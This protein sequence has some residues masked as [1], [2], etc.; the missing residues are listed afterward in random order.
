MIYLP[1]KNQTWSPR[2][3]PH[4][5]LRQLRHCGSVRHAAAMTVLDILE[6]EKMETCWFSKILDMEGFLIWK[7]YPGYPKLIIHLMFGCSMKKT[8]NFKKPRYGKIVE[9]LHISSNDIDVSKCSES[10]IFL[11]RVT[12]LNVTNWAFKSDSEKWKFGP[13]QNFSTGIQLPWNFPWNI[14]EL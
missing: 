6:N 14:M 10:K 12:W 2:S 5:A 4:L 11:R 7:G 8:S 1:K 3:R 9:P 13:F